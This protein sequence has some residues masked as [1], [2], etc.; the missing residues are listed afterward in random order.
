MSLTFCGYTR[1]GVGVC[2]AAFVM[3]FSSSGEASFSICRSGEFSTDTGAACTDEL[4]RCRLAARPPP[5]SN[6]VADDAD[7]L[8]FRS[9][10][11]GRFM[12]AWP[13]DVVAAGAAR[14]AAAGAAGTGDVVAVAR[15]AAAAEVAGARITWSASLLVSGAETPPVVVVLAAAAAEAAAAAAAAVEFETASRIL[16]HAVAAICLLKLH[17]HLL[18]SICVFV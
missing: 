7:L 18:C 5:A 17:A 9:S 6:A 10:V 16:K 3:N 14:T 4:K 13:T 8:P 2:I 12:V 15:V 11:S 1:L